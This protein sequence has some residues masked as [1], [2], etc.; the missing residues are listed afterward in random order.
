MLAVVMMAQWLSNPLVN[1][2]EAR[3]ALLNMFERSH[4]E[5]VQNLR[6]MNFAM[7]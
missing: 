4:D 7:T 2:A 3:L 1:Q 6:T 5:R